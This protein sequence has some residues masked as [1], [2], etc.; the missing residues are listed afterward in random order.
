MADVKTYYGRLLHII[1]VNDE[2]KR[3]WKG[4][5][6][7]CGLPMLGGF[8]GG[9]FGGKGGAAIGT[10]IGAII[11]YPITDRYLSMVR[12][13]KGLNDYEREQLVHNVCILVGDATIDALTAY[14][15]SADNRKKLINLLM[16]FAK[17][18]KKNN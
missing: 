7:Q 2:L 14:I 3:T 16:N 4:I 11:A 12:V 1:E 18:L 5:A 8:L 17:N 10:V 6:I 9:F 15:M 13:L